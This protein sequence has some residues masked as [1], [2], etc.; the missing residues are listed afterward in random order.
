MKKKCIL[1]YICARSAGELLL[2]GFWRLYY[3]N[4]CCF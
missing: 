4:F 3:S 1:K 2:V